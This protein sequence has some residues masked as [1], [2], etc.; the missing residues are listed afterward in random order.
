MPPISNDWLAPLKPE[1]SKPYYAKLYKTINEEYHTH[2]IYPPA[3]DIFNAFAF[4]PLSKVKAVI[5]GQDPYHEPGTG[6]RACVSLF[7]HRYRFHPLLSIF[8][9]NFTK[10]VAATFQ[11]MDASP[12]GQ[13]RAYCCSTPC[14]PCVLTRQT[15]TMGIGWEEFTDASDPYLK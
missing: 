13:T 15:P 14:S 10:T 8:I 1:F 3:D 7:S 12:N 6:S 4:T 2:E 9:R 5:L 11:T